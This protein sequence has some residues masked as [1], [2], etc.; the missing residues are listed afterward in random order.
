M[1][2]TSIEEPYAY[3]T[4]GKLGLLPDHPL[5][6]TLKSLEPYNGQ[7]SLDKFK[8]LHFSRWQ[9]FGEQTHGD[10]MYI[11]ECAYLQNHV[12]ELILTYQQSH[13]YI[14][15]YM[16]ELIETVRSL[17][18]LLIYLFPTDIEW[19]INNAAKERKT[20]LPDIWKD[21]ID[22]VT[23]YMENSNYG[24]AH[25]ITGL[26]GC[27]EFFK[28]RQRLELDIIKQLPIETY[29]HEVQVDFKQ[30]ALEENQELIKLLLTNS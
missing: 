11:F 9:K 24:K 29:V 15:A 6:L 4:Y 7:A 1:Q 17:N 19:T 23:A 14:K 5:F 13:D 25:H 28:E 12:V 18:P 21:W 16:K 22:D 26:A 10:V 20:D 27:I 30:P 2:H 3:V 8:K